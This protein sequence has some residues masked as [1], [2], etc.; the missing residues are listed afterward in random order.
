MQH[1]TKMNPFVTSLCLLLALAAL[2]RGKSSSLLE[3]LFKAEQQKTYYYTTTSRDD[4]IGIE[5]PYSC[6]GNPLKGLI[7]NTQFGNYDP[8]ATTIDASMNFYFVGVDSVMIDDPD[9]VGLEAAFNWASL[10]E[11]LDE[12]AAQNRHAVLSFTLHYP[13]QPLM[14]PQ[15]LLENL[16]LHYYADFLGGGW[17]P[18]YGDPILLRAIELFIAAFGEKYE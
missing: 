9:E 3:R 7:G 5:N 1:C 2:P 4:D 18:D 8:W 13:G 15:Y 12:S 10:E 16:T 17:S 6:A 14:V 11:K